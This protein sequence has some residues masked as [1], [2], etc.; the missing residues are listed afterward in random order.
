[1]ARQCSIDRRP[2]PIGRT[3][4]AQAARPH[5]LIG[6]ALGHLWVH[7]TAAINDRAIALLE[8]APG[9]QVLELGCGPGR[10]AAEIARHGAQVTGLDPSPAMIAAAGR[11]NRAAIDAG[12]V[13]LLLGDASAVP[14]PDATYQAAL[15][16]HT[17]YFWR[18]LD[19]GL[20]EVRRVLVPGGRL[21][22]G[23]RPAERGR[24]RRLDPKVYRI[25]TTNQLMQALGVAGFAEPIVHE[26]RSAA[27]V[28]ATVPHAGG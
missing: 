27:I 9:E 13:R 12:T 5:G 22:I 23:F 21:V 25:P 26:A 18:D 14:R 4:S 20:R 24:P 28:V 11:R 6:W 3:V 15:A 10:T 7:E 2:G 17:V 19:A 8:P 16:V 1:M